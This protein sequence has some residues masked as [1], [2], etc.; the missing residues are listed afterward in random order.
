MQKPMTSLP[1]KNQKAFTLVELLVS[2]SVLVIVLTIGAINYLRF[3]NKQSLYK[4]GSAVEVMIKDARSKAQNGFLG[5]EEIGFCSKLASIEVFSFLNA[6][7]KISLSA[8]VRCDNNDLLT[9]DNYVVNQ[10]NIVLNQNFRISFLPLRGATVSLGGSSVASGSATLSFG[11][12]TVI[13]GFDNGGN[14]NVEY[15]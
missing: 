15:K 9:Y 4:A 13:L 6:E 5:D 10:G 7:D 8:Q 2:V 11:E 1:S 14:I 12:D 3:L